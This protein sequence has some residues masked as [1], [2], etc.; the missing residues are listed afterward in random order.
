MTSSELAS[1]IDFTILKHPIDLMV[2]L[3]GVK[4]VKEKGFV[5]LCAHPGLIGTIKALDPTV[6]TASVIDFPMGMNSDLNRICE[7]AV[8]EAEELDIVF[9]QFRGTNNIPGIKDMTT[10]TDAAHN[11]GKIVKFIL[12]VHR[13]GNDDLKKICEHAVAS[14]VDYIKTHTGFGGQGAFPGEITLIKSFITGSTTKVKASGGI[15]N[16]EQAIQLINS[17]ADRLG[18]SGN[19]AL[20]IL[21]QL[22]QLNKSGEVAC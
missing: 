7:V 10:L 1:K 14:K 15:Q 13:W 19:N 16:L 6:R 8:S 11:H 3:E 4:S 21:D 20:A 22:D 2:L 5:C 9:Q 18:I 12:E 17:G